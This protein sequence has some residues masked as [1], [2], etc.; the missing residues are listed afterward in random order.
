MGVVLEDADLPPDQRALAML[1][2]VFVADEFFDHAKLSATP[3]VVRRM[4]EY[5]LA[6]RTAILS[7]DDLAV[8][9]A[10]DGLVLYVAYLAWQAQGHGT[11]RVETLRSFLVNSYADRFQGNNV[12]WIVGE[13]AGAYIRTVA[14]RTGCEIINDYPE[15]EEPTALHGQDLRP[16]LVGVNRD[17]GMTIEN[18]WFHRMFT[19][20]TPRF[21]FTDSQ[22]QVLLLA[23]D[24]LTDV[25]VA[26]DL[27]IS[28]DA[29]KKRWVGIYD[30]VDSVLPGLLPESPPGGRGAEKRR[31]L[32]MHLRDCP[33]ELR[34]FAR[35]TYQSANSRAG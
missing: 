3:Y 26:A 29:V 13:T 15:W 5:A 7:D 10:T 16:C 28:T 21:G 14:L 31:A 11:V 30:R 24:G 34:P 20:M 32:L 17:G 35:A 2:T 12:R 6:G 8:K 19:Y 25:E 4:V 1:G 23:R 9:N 33:E 18:Y 22:R 27:Q